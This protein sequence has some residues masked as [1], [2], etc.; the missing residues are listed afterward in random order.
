MDSPLE[1]SG[2]EPPVPRATQVQPKAIIAGFGCMPPSLDYLRLPPVNISGGE[3][4]RNLGTEALSRG[5]GIR[6]DI[7][8]ALS[9]RLTNVDIRW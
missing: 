2:F 1:G 4:K 9:Q 3:P 6:I 7:P 5:I 8:P